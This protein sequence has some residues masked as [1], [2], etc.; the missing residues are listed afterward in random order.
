MIKE[1]I[2]QNKSTKVYALVL[3]TQEANAEKVIRTDPLL[4]KA[5]TTIVGDIAEP[6]LGIQESTY[7]KLISE[8]TDIFHLAAVYHLEVPKK[9]AWRVN[10]IGTYNMLQ[11]ALQCPNLFCFTHFSSMVAPGRK[12]GKIQEDSLDTNVS[13]HENHY[14]ITKHVSEVLVRK[15]KDRLP[16]IIIRPAA[17]IGDSKTGITDKFDGFYHVFELGTGGKNLGRVL[18]RIQVKNSRIKLPLVPVD[19][20]ARAVATVSDQEACIGHTFHL[21]EFDLSINTLLDVIFGKE[22]TNSKFSLPNKLINSIIHSPIYRFLIAH[23]V[24]RLLLRKGFQ[25][26]IELLQSVDTY[27][28]GE[29]QTDNSTRFLKTQGIV[30]PRFKDYADTIV[31]F[32]KKNRKNRTLRR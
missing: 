13:L 31:A 32:Q 9:I 24:T 11:F 29:F 7:S 5:V 12:K 26:P 19:Y 28:M 3:K 18:P 1:L 20:L 8:V 16:L 17:V 21:G 22:P 23:K 14:E 25:I 30:C 10:V 27:E 15:Y 6:K 2:S 4:E